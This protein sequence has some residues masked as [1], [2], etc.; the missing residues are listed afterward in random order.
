M[1]SADTVVLA[2]GLN[3]A[4]AL[5]GVPLANKIN[6]PLLLTSDKD[7]NAS[8]LAEIGR[9]GAKKVIILGGEGAVS[10]KV[11]KKLQAEALKTERI[12]GKTRYSTAAYLWHRGGCL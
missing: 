3:Y 1:V 8:T 10:E 11:E 2:S 4:D 9:L 7:L 12:F 6:A 5:A